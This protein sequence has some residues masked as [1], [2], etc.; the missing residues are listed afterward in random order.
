MDSVTLIRRLNQHRAWANDNLF[1][2]AA[3]LSDAQLRQ[4]FQIGQ[5]SIWQSLCHM[6]AAEY[7]WLEALSGNQEGLTPGDVA[8]KLPGNQQGEGALKSLVELKQAWTA[9]ASRWDKY[10]ANL[11]AEALDGTVFRKRSGSPPDS[12]PMGA[13]C[14]DVLL[15]VCM[16]AHYTAAQVVNMLRQCGMTDLPATMLIQLARQETV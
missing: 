11:T 12:K 4:S 6:Y 13:R 7:V 9:L 15:H 2:A 10:L 5:G 3:Q 14:A 8:G 1:G 16:H